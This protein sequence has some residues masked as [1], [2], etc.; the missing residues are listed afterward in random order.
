MNNNLCGVFKRADGA[1][2]GCRCGAGPNGNQGAVGEPATG[3]AGSGSKDENGLNK[4]R[5]GYTSRSLNK[6]DAYQRV[7]PGIN[8]N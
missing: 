2:R 8:F 7:P 6:V 4:R 1:V 3:A 5:Y